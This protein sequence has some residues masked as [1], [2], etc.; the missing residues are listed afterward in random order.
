MTAIR[1]SRF[2][3]FSSYSY[4]TA[5]GRG[6]SGYPEGTPRAT[7][8]SESSRGLLGLGLQVKLEHG[9]PSFSI[10]AAAFRRSQNDS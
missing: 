8:W 6:E 7:A 10:V 4:V 9:K 3:H 2:V 1:P 5:C